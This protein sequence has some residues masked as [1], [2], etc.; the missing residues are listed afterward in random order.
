MHKKSS[1]K[2]FTLIELLVVIAIIAILAAILFPVFQTVRENARRA[3]CQSNEKQLG[4][5]FTQYCQDNEEH[6]P[7][8]GTK[9]TGAGWAGQVYTYIKSTGVYTCPDEAY[10]PSAAGDTAVSYAY[11]INL[12]RI[13]QAGF[14]GSIVKLN[15]PTKTVLL[16]EV[17]AIPARVT[18]PATN[19]GLS[20]AEGNGSQSAAASGYYSAT[21]DGYALY[22]R[23][24]DDYAY[25]G[26]GSYPSG[27]F[28]TGYLGNRNSTGAT[29]NN[30]NIKPLGRHSDGSN[31]LFT[32]S[33]VKWLRG[34]QVSDYRTAAQSTD[35]QS[36]Y[37]AAGTEDT[38]GTYVGTFSPI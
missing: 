1:S 38:S 7:Q 35:P 31:F 8:N 5:A 23:P 36:S 3:S 2:A 27:D 32:D 15:G 34:S 26:A 9:N 12:T 22:P 11:N 20:G 6:F 16:C 25:A 21:T 4:I 17:S 33:H 37:Y 13:I 29:P 18:D 30:P 24:D 10:A 14:G 19:P 28:A